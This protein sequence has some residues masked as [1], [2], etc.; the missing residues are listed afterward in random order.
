[1]KSIKQVKRIV[2]VIIV[3]A[4]AVTTIGYSVILSDLKKGNEEFFETEKVEEEQNESSESI[5]LEFLEE[6]CDPESVDPWNES[7]L[8]IKEIT[9]LD[10]STVFIQAYISINCAFW[11]EGGGFYVH[12]NTITL[13]YYIGQEG[14]KTEEGLEGLVM[15]NCICAT[16]LSFTLS[17]LNST[18]FVF[19]LESS[20]RTYYN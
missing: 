20:S 17:N 1:M 9:W 2:L 15:A 12:N 16:G 4:I 19:E 13:T 14:F 6:C 7:Q 3:I 18:D 8:G 11:I 10:N 5:I